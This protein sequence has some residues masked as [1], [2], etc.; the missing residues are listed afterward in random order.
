MVRIWL[1]ILLLSLAACMPTTPAQEL[2]K[3][4]LAQ[5]PAGELLQSN[6]LNKGGVWRLRQTTLLEAGGK[7]FP[8]EGFL[9]LDLVKQEARL[10]AMN[11]VGLVLF[12][13]LVTPDDQQL[14][15]AV[16]QLQQLDGFA[17]G[18]AQSL[19]QIFFQTQ[20]QVGDKIENITNLQRVK[21]S[22]SGG[23]INFSY[24]CRGDLR[25]VRQEAKSGNW[26]VA[27][28][29]Y[30]QHDNQRVPLHIIMNDYRQRLKL[31]LWI[32]AARQE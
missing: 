20:P 25:T 27:Y 32:S 2:P 3:D 11:G 8:L 21:R 13:L 17:S 23:T 16:P 6:W 19:R 15:R 12:D 22:I 1:F 5:T 26:R 4:C 18:V 30:Q 14:H 24:D 31:S 9:R 29:K 10:V 28:D 7:K